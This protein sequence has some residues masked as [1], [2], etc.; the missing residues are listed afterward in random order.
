MRDF[1]FCENINK[2]DGDTGIFFLKIDSKDL[3]DLRKI[4][5]SQFK[6]TLSE[7]RIPTKKMNSI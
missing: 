5:I 4:V 3:Q 1:N 7:N 6:N 2:D